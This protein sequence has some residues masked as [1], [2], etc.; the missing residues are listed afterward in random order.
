MSDG[1]ENAH[2]KLAE[3]ESRILALES[4]P[5]TG[6]SADTDAALQAYQAQMGAK[7][8][9]VRDLMSNEVGDIDKIRT[10]RDN[11]ISEN[12]ALRKEIEK[13]NYRIHHLKSALL[14]KLD[15]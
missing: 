13:L 11:A 7:L 4:N 6:S 12:A 15:A 9:M 3:L 14:D 10:E 8:R 2:A 5:N 1:N